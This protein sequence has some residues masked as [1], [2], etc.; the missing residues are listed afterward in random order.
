M[1]KIKVEYDNPDVT[2]N[3]ND[4]SPE[5]EE[6]E[7]RVASDMHDLEELAKKYLWCISWQNGGCRDLSLVI[8]ENEPTE[9]MAY[10]V[11]AEETNETVEEL[12]RLKKKG[13]FDVEMVYKIYP[14]NYNE[15]KTLDTKP[16]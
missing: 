16:F 13:D 9:S 5:Q 12:R 2:T 11:I 3:A 1:S 6:Y 15:I 14:T 4:V 10:E 8:C 7:L